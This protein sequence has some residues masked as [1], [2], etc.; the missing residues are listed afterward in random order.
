MKALLALVAVLYFDAHNHFTG[1][2]ARC[3][4]GTDADGVEHSD[5]VREYGYASSPGIEPT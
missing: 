4:L 1:R 3:L 5:I 2:H